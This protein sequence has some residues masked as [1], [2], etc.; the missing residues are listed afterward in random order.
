MSIRVVPSATLE[1]ICVS[2]RVNSAEPCTRGARCRPR[3][4]SGGSRPW[5][6]R[7]AASCRRRSAC[8]S[9]SFSSFAKAALTS[10]A[11]SG[12]ASSSPSPAASVRRRPPPRPRRS[13]PG[14]RASRRSGSPRRAWRRASPGSARAAPRRSVGLLDLDLVLAGLAAQLLDG[15]DQLLDLAVGDVER[16]EDLLL[17]DAVGAA[18][19]HQDRLVGAGDDQVDL[20]LLVAL[21]LGV[22]DEVAVE[23]ADPDRADVLGDRDRGDRQ[24]R[25]GAVHRQDVVGVDVVHRHRLADELGLAVPALGEQRAD[26]AVDHP[27]GQRRLLAR[28]RLAAEERAR[29][30]ARGVV[31]LLDVDRQR[32]EVDVAQVAGRRGAEDHRVPG[33]HD[34]G[35]ARLAGEL[36]GLEG[37]LVAAD[38]G[39]DAGDFE[40]AHVFAFPFGRPVGGLFSQ[41][42]R[43]LTRAMLARAARRAGSGRELR[44]RDGDL[45]VDCGVRPQTRSGSPPPPPG[46]RSRSRVARARRRRSERRSASKRSRSRLEQSR[47][48]PQVR[49]VHSPR[50]G[51]RSSR[52]SSRTRPGAGARWPR[53]RRAAPASAVAWRRSGS[54]AAE[55]QPEVADPA[56][57]RRALR[58]GEIE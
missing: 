42:S 57:T 30:L 43:S 5:R 34:D 58:A 2:P 12:S 18:L 9:M 35:S 46:S 17:G 49:I 25:R 54:G 4:R 16:V 19:D 23:L 13:R 7:R 48:L 33:A 1:K 55:P 39:R 29:D 31:L 22:D 52:R 26:R 50:I 38:L 45:A 20:E 8:G 3:S 10:A 11:R 37:D 56:A 40:H 53:P 44:E 32:Q 28:A 21:L 41:N 47:P 27:R 51:S 36:S 15:G 14:A 24:R 6:G